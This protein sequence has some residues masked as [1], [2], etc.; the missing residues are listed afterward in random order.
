LQIKQAVGALHHDVIQSFRG[1]Y[2][3]ITFKLHTSVASWGI[4]PVTK[5]PDPLSG[6]IDVA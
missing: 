1:H 5:D 2:L 4:K 3:L 6:L